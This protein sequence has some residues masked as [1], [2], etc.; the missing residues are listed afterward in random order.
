[1]DIVGFIAE[2]KIEEALENGYFN[3][4]PAFG[5]I[6][7]SLSGELFVAKWWREKIIREERAREQQK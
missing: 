3:G 5:R 4:L 1:M 2:R 7:C 6:D